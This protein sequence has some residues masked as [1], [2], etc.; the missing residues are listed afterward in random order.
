M[1]H[2]YKL[3]RQYLEGLCSETRCG[4]NEF[5]TV[6]KLHSGSSSLDLQPL[7]C[8][9][10]IW[11]RL[12]GQC[13]LEIPALPKCNIHIYADNECAASRNNFL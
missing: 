10:H 9:S 4:H 8:C 13:E 11:H 3:I 12:S 6:S 7:S 5:A 2:T 1:V